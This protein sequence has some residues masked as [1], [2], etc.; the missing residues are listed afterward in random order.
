VCG[1]CVG[2]VVVTGYNYVMCVI[3]V[4]VVVVV[5]VVVVVD[6]IVVLIGDVVVGWL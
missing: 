4:V 2:A 5:C 3:R 6:V 1:G